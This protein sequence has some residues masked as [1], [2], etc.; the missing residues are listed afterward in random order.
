MM[1]FAAA[2]QS[3]MRQSLFAAIWRFGCHLGMTTALIGLAPAAGAADMFKGTQI[4]AR[5]CAACHGP[6]GISVMPGAPHLARGEKMMQSDMAMLAALKSGRG[7]MPSYMG[8]LSDAEILDVIAYTR[9][10]R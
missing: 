7:A 1:S 8:V 6:N 10:L 9:S 3:L 5:H 2:G 4:Y